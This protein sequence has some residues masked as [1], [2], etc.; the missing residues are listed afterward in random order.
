MDRRLRLAAD[1][2]LVDKS[3]DLSTLTRTERRVMAQLIRGKD[4]VGIGRLLGISS[5]TVAN[6]SRAIFTKLRVHNRAELLPLCSA[7]NSS[8]RSPERSSRSAYPDVGVFRGRPPLRPFCRA[9]T[10]RA[11][12]RTRPRITPL[13]STIARAP[14]AISMSCSRS[15]PSSTVSD[16]R[17]SALGSIATSAS[18]AGS[19]LA[20]PAI[21]ARGTIF[22]AVFSRSSAVRAATSSSASVVRIRAGAVATAFAVLLIG[23]LIGLLPEGEELIVVVPRSLEYEALFAPR[24]RTDDGPAMSPRQPNATAQEEFDHDLAAPNVSVKMRHGCAGVVA[25]DRSKPNWPDAFAAHR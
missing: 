9:E 11:S 17:L 25:R 20:K 16:H 22:V 13:N 10:A 6:H 7:M 1:A 5:Q 15:T 18:I 4:N 8:M 2:I 14:T 23:L 12:E 21:F 3:M 19:A 24:D